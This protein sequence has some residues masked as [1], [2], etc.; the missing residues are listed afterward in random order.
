MRRPILIVAAVGLLVA[1]T[2]AHALQDSG[3][4]GARPGP[5]AVY[6][7]ATSDAA[8]LLPPPPPPGKATGIKGRALEPRVFTTDA[9]GAAKLIAQH[10]TDEIDPKRRAGADDWARPVLIYDRT[11]GP[12][13]VF[14]LEIRTRSRLGFDQDQS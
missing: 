2:S 7:A 1:A 10:V 14:L 8:S 11:R 13:E 5:D 6:H 12:S 9:P 3:K 4:H